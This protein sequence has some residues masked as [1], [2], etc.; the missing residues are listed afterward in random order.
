MSKSF[1]RDLEEAHDEA[2]VVFLTY[3]AIMSARIA[4]FKARMKR[5]IL[6]A[7]DFGQSAD[8]SKGILKLIRARRLSAT[9]CMVTEAAFLS[10]AQRLKPFEDQVDIGLHFNLTHGYALGPVKGLMKGQRLPS[11]NQLLL[12]TAFRRI[13]K[14]Q[15]AHELNRQLDRFEAAFGSLPDFIDGH[16]HVHHLPVIREGVK[17]VWRTR[18]FKH[19]PYFRSLA[20][21]SG[22]RQGGFK[23]K[24]IQYYG[25]QGFKKWLNK[26]HIFHNNDF[27]GIY[28]FNQ[29]Q[30]LS[31]LSR[32]FDD[33]FQSIS[34]G[35][36]VMCHP[37]SEGADITDPIYKTRGLEQQ[38]LLSE[39]F[40]QML[41]RYEVK[42][43]R[44]RD[45]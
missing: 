18:L 32:C 28:E 15:V 38:F 44:G 5:V 22:C 13:D 2:M 37:G 25:A 8:I 29:V 33:F 14:K 12:K 35:G 17:Q 19:K 21:V 30:D 42:L 36:L 11:I 24:V 43:V 1:Q 26:N 45:L 10:M 40:D 34:D 41:A 16:Q 23:T 20:Q 7:D 39:A 31:S 3:F 27:S 9:S 4:E 6:C